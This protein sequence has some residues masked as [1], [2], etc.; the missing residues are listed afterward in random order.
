MGGCRVNIS[1]S[2]F[3]KVLHN[4]LLRCNL[5]SSEKNK[6]RTTTHFKRNK[7]PPPKKKHR[8]DCQWLTL[9]LFSCEIKG[10]CDL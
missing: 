5:A 10:K 3:R 4:S 9:S 7:L 8:E 1:G 6:N 2:L